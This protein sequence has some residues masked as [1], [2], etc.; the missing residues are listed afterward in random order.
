[1]DKPTKRTGAR[2]LSG[3]TLLIAAATIAG[4]GRVAVA[5][6]KRSQAEVA[7]QDHPNG[8]ERCKICAPFLPPDQ[9]RLV[10]GPVGRQGWRNVF[11]GPDVL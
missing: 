9:R 4:A 7:Y 3:R 10:V 6:G 5:A 11:T 2:P 1:M 8:V